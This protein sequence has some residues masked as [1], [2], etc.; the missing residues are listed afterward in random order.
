MRYIVSLLFVVFSSLVY[1]QSFPPP[2]AMANSSQQKLINEFIEVS[3]YREAL[4]N[5]AK[6]YL[7]LKM[8]DYSVDPPKELLTKE[9]ARSI[10]KNFNFDDFKISLYSAFSFIPEKELKEL[11]NFYKGIGGRL[12]RNN[13]ILLMDSNIDLN[14]KNHMDYAIEN[15]K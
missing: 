10:I 5:Y 13:S 15:I 6:E 11:I 2:P 3:H 1:A 14:I 12:S 7:E 4:V 9:Q 8:F